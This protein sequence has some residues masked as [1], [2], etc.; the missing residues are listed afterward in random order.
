MLRYIPIRKQLTFMTLPFT[1]TYFKAEPVY[2]RNRRTHLGAFLGLSI[3]SS[4][5]TV[6]SFLLPV[7][8]L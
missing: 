7:K 5:E 8:R 2:V 1:K 4:H 3:V 6:H